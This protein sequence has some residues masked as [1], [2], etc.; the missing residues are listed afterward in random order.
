[1]EIV[2][3]SEQALNQITSFQPGQIKIKDEVFDHPIIIMPQKILPWTGDLSRATCESWLAYQPQ[4]ILIGTGAKTI[5]PTQEIMALFWQKKIGV[6]VMTT[7]SACRT[8][9]ILSSEGRQVLA[10]LVV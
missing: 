3:D 2:P 9:N 5:F 8:F 7:S 6:E 1:M 10:A 4:V